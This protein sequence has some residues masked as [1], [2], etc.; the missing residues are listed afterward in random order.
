MSQCDV[1]QYATLLSH[2]GLKIRGLKSVIT[3]EL[4]I[5]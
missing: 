3:G 1:E 4:T 2:L 5:D